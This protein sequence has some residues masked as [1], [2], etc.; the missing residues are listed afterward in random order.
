[1]RNLASG[2]APPRPPRPVEDVFF[3]IPLSVPVIAG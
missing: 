1:M 3:L 2:A